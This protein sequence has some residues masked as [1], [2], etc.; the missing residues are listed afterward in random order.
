MLFHIYRYINLSASGVKFT[1]SN[2]FSVEMDNKVEI[3]LLLNPLAAKEY[4]LKNN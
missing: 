1:R 4:H 3:V 2:R